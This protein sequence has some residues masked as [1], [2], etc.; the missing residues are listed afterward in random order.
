MVHEADIENLISSGHDQLKR[1]G[2]TYI[3]RL[4]AYLQQLLGLPI[5]VLP[6]PTNR[7]NL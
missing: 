5:Q 3:R 1:T 7:S 2:M 4:W 6:L